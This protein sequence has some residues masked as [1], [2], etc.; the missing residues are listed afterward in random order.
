MTTAWNAFMNEEITV[1]P[2]NSGPLD[3]LTFSVK[4]VFDIEN[5]TSSAGNPDWLKTHEKAEKHASVIET[6]LQNGATLKGTTVTDELMY[7]LNGENAHYGTPV[8]PAD[9]KRIPGGSSSGSAVAAGA[10]LTDF[11]VGTDTGGSIRIPGSY[12]GVYGYRPTHG[13]ISTDGLIPLAPTFDTVG[14]L[15]KRFD[16]FEEVCHVLF[17]EAGD[18]L[19]DEGEDTIEKALLVPDIVSQLEPQIQHAVSSII[20]QMARAVPDQA[21]TVLH[22]NGLSHLREAFR[23]LQGLEIWA[24]HGEWI[25]KEKPVFGEDIGSRFKWA[26]T[27]DIGIREKYNKIRKRL[28]QQMQGLLGKNGV[29]IM[30]TAPGPAPLRNAAGEALNQTRMQTLEMTCIAGLAGLPQITLPWA[31]VDGLPIGISVIAAPDQDRKLLKWIRQTGEQLQ[32]V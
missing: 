20:D 27:L 12:C 6:L 10:G 4:D 26:S 5:H 11:A 24:T 32:K 9:S 19:L 13:L 2:L 31:E 3:G 8:N 1:N 18:F 28:R 15:S 7:S 23:H 21:E 22:P 17:E 14:I 30:P 29:L 25:E 16:V